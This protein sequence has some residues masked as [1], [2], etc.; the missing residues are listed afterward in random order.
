M[1]TIRE[2]KRGDSSDSDS[3]VERCLASSRST[4]DISDGDESPSPSPSKIKKEAKG[5]SSSK[6]KTSASSKASP[7]VSKNAPGKKDELGEGSSKG[8]P[9]KDSSSVDGLNE[10]VAALLIDGCNTKFP[11]YSFDNPQLYLAYSSYRK[12]A[13]GDVLAHGPGFSP[14]GKLYTSKGSGIT[15]DTSRSPPR[16]CYN[17]GEDHWRKDCAFWK[18]EVSSAE[19]ESVSMEEIEAASVEPVVAVSGREFENVKVES[20]V[21]AIVPM[22]VEVTGDLVTLLRVVVVV[23]LI[24]VVKVKPGAYTTGTHGVS[25]IRRR[26]RDD[27]GTITVGQV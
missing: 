24:E 11:P 2:S 6:T 20:A 14:S 26:A 10:G 23:F 8:S 1:G 5:S 18:R 3:D 21:V 13:S 9:S 12:N 25:V 17:C 22:V 7:K 4:S 27:V 15:Y 19:G 16:P